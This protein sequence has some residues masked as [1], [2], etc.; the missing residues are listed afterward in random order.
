MRNK[1]DR[2]PLRGRRV[3]IAI[4]AASGLAATHGATARAASLPDTATSPSAT[5]AEAPAD[6]LHAIEQEIE[7][8]RAHL[9]ALN[10][11]A[12]ELAIKTADL[13]RQL[14]EA[15][16]KVQSSEQK[17]SDIEARLYALI[18]RQDKTV[19]SLARRRDSIARLTGALESLALNRPPT[20]GVTPDDAKEAAR[21]AMLLNTLIPEIAAQADK[22]EKELATLKEVH[23]QI[24]RE[25]GEVVAAAKSLD[26]ERAA[27]K[28]KVAEMS[29]ERDTTMAS[30]TAE[31]DRLEALAR[32]A[33]DIRQF[34][35]MLSAKGLDPAPRPKPAPAQEEIALLHGGIKN[36]KGKLR[37]PVTGEVTL[38]Y[39]AETEDG[40]Q[41]RGIR[42]AARDG[43]QVVSPCDGTV[44]FSGP[45]RG[46]GLLLILRSDDGYHF[47]LSGMS[48]IDAVTRQ[49]L[50][51][52]EPIGVMGKGKS[53]QLGSSNQD[54]GPELYVEMR[55][56][57]DPIDPEP[58]FAISREKVSG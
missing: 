37:P 41:N 17:L 45:F 56:D 16:D 12:E 42:I 9:D 14:V 50:L 38:A 53:G 34:L 4:L 24:G 30:A 44:V 47:V 25:Q 51:A 10:Q 33:A 1:A 11:Q 55:H 40:G 23:E 15:A 43:A 13:Q 2:R 48:R 46:Y 29:A 32:Q 57:G 22:L 5:P 49:K 3:L 31:Q 7:Q 21:S 27:L 54:N 8:G 58:W 26:T 39:G 52:G 18:E 36:L 19:R 20:L 28:D 35:A 6:Q